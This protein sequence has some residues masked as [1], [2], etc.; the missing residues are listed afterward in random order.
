MR[1]FV[2]LLLTVFLIFCLV[3][4]AFAADDPEDAASEEAITETLDPK[5]EAMLDWARATADDDTHGYSQEY[6]YGPDYDCTS[7]VSRALM[8]AGFPLDRYLSTANMIA[9][10]P[11]LGFVVYQKD[12]VAPQRG[13]ILIRL[14]EHAEICIGDGG[15]VAAH[16]DYDG[17]TG[18]STGH[19]IEYRVG[20]SRYGCPFCRDQCYDHILRYEEQETYLEQQTEEPP[21]EQDEAFQKTIC[22]PLLRDFLSMIEAQ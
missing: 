6:R 5:I 9:D 19:E 16:Q 4:T 2:T 17:Q 18:D 10:L 3:L 7:F 13:D 22:C 14:G 21:A 20:D 15:C 12:E 8:E 11:A 1:R